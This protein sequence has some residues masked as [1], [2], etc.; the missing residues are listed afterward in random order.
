MAMDVKTKRAAFRELHREGCFVLPN[1]WDLGSARR[2]EGMGFKALASTSAGLAWSMG[3]QDGELS[4]DE[5]LGHLRVLCAATELPVNADFE[6]GFA[7]DAESVGANVALA[8]GTGVA[9]I[10]IEDRTGRELYELGL[11]VERIRA[12]RE[13]LDRVGED[14]LLVGRSEG[15]LI[16]Q[17]SLDATIERL[18]AYAD[19]G[20]DCLY[21]PGIRDMSAIAAVVAAVAP[22]PVNVLLMGPEMRV[23]E[24]AAAGVRRVS[25]GGSLAAAAWKGFDAAARLLVEEG[26]MPARG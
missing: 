3:R 8:V 16:G 15:F 11:A 17:T 13:A 25:V 4:R 20:A 9:G 1:P 10:S 12:A 19:A 2:L 22:K 26:R 18:V 5:V 7:D 21:A 14:A 6:A 23:S 24:L